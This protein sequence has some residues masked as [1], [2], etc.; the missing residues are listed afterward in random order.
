M[1]DTR[2][3]YEQVIIDHNK[4][5]RNFKALE[6]ARSCE[7]YNPLCGD[8]F[9]IYVKLDGDVIEEVSFTGA[10]CAISKSAASV[11]TTVVKG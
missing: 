11:M 6:G 10:G 4:K 9:T 1:S 3:L 5:P 8:Q 2:Q 7:G